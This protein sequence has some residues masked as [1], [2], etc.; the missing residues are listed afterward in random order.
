MNHNRN[1]AWSP[2]YTFLLGHG[3]KWIGFAHCISVAKS[4]LKAGWLNVLDLKGIKIFLE[5]LGAKP[6]VWHNHGRENQILLSLFLFKL[7][8]RVQLKYTLDIKIQI[9]FNYLYQVKRRYHNF[10][11]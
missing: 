9:I 11:I 1:Q 2:A 5:A 6:S 7:K 4:F 10:M 8:L 3:D